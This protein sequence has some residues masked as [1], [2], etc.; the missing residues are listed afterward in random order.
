HPIHSGMWGGP[1]PNAATALTS[2]LAQLVDARGASVVP[3]L[4]DDAPE[5]SA[6][7]RAE[8]AALPFDADAFRRDAGM[9]PGA[10]FVGE[11]DRTVYERIWYRP[12]LALT[13]LEGMPL[14]TAANQ[15]MAEARAR[16]EVRVAP[17]QDARRIAQLV[18]EFVKRDPPAGVSVDTLV[19]AE[20]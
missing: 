16:V 5:L 13:A 4:Y 20:V 3:G 7:E 1:V 19:N 9:A 8:L 18:A 6:A 17:G 10:A 2:L 11:S 14:A 15:L 12:A